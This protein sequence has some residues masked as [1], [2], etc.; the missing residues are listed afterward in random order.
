M[1]S[2]DA[3]T[4]FKVDGLVAVITGGATGIGLMMAKALEANGAAKVYVVGRRKDKLEEAANQA[5]HG[6]I[7]PIQGDVSEV[8]CINLLIAN[9]GISGP[10]ISSVP[11]DASLSDFKKHAWNTPM[12]EFTNTYAVNSTGVWYTVL[13]FLELLDAGNKKGNMG[14]VKSQVIATSSIGGYNR[15]SAAGIA[16]N[17]SKAATTH[18]IKQLATLMVPHSIRFNALAPGLFPSELAA[19]LLKLA[20]GD[21]TK[22]GAFEK[23]FIP[24]GRTGS[25][26]D[27]AGAILYLASRAGA[28]LNG[29]IV[30]IDGGRLSLLPATY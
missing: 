11:K 14:E 29:T 10:Q 15:M 21:M 16:Y 30:V 20:N 7:V 12:E 5:K 25:E 19:P 9:S 26:E 2:I 24:A 3:A 4:L 17:T 22:E 13:A 8:G 6:N 28:Y 23:S 18:M 1:A 27:M